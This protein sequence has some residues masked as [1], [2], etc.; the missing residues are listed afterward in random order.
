MLD[1]KKA[2]FGLQNLLDT[3][4][5]EGFNLNIS[6]NIRKTSMRKSGTLDEKAKVVSGS[7]SDGDIIALKVR[8]CKKYYF[9]ETL[10]NTTEEFSTMR[11]LP[12]Y[13]INKFYKTGACKLFHRIFNELSV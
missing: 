6:T 4:T 7:A 8:S 5:Y 12:S 9:L 3:S 2:Y 1:C 11:P 13:K 10:Q